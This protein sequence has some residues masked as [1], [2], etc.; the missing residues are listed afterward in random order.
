MFD[1]IYRKMCEY[2]QRQIYIA[3]KYIVWWIQQNE[4]GTLYVEIS[5]YKLGQTYNSLTLA[6]NVDVKDRLFLLSAM[7]NWKGG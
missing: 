6:L 2:L 1:Q 4:I 3:C 5:F 7:K